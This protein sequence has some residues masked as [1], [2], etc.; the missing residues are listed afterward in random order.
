L[1]VP[2]FF[3]AKIGE[4]RGIGKHRRSQIIFSQGDP[5]DAVYYVQMGHAFPQL[6]APSPSFLLRFLSP[7]HPA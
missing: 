7:V 1:F 5:A 3:L 2:K 6:R 4:G